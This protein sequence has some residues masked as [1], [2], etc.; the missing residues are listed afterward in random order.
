DAWNYRVPQHRK[1]LILL[2]RRDGGDFPWGKPKKQTT[3]RD[4]IGDLPALDPEPLES[5]GARRLDYDENQEPKPSPF[6]REMR[7]KAD[8]GVIHDHMTRRVRNDDFKIFTV[9]D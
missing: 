4:A 7:K 1:R 8:K 5:V 2:A 3:L 6:A 9:M